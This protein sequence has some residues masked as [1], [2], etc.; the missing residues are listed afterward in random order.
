[1]RRRYEYWVVRYVPDAI[2]GEFVN[3][4]VVAGEG[5]EWAVRRV[6]NLSR[7]SRLGGSAVVSKPF[8][9]RIENMIEA[10]L[11]HME[12]LI[13][14]LPELFER[15]Y[16]EDLRTRMNNSVQLSAPR[17]VL[18][19]SAEEAADLAFDLM[20]VDSQKDV[21]HRTR[22]L[23]VRRLAHA[24]SDDPILQGHV[25]TRQLVAI[26][27]ETTRI[28][29]AVEDGEVR[30][31]S[32]AWAFDGDPN[33]LQTNIRAWNYMMGLIR[34]RGGDLR[35]RSGRGAGELIEIPDS[36]EINA[37][38]ATPSRQ[39]GAA[40]LDLAIRGWRDLGVSPVPD[41]QSNQIVRQAREL[42]M[43]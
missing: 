31:L 6:S 26:G 40:Q 10:E 39:E 15:G 22:T 33:R 36:V 7:A 4:G 38:Y 3:V 12:I 2:R 20:V 16:L 37:V 8:L 9:L 21:R 25:R 32:Q 13:G 19:S 28:D 17:A 35:L 18:A 11:R 14:E 5:D 41:G 23:A 1:M 43:A 24:F 42:V 27:P 30:Q 34:R 29:F